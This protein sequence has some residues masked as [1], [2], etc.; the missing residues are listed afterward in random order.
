[1]HAREMSNVAP[2]VWISLNYDSNI[3]LMHACIGG[4]NSK[5]LTW[6]GCWV[7]GGL[8]WPQDKL[9]VWLPTKTFRFCIMDWVYILGGPVNCTHHKLIKLWVIYIYM[10]AKLPDIILLS[11]VLIII[12]L[13][14]ATHD[15]LPS[16]HE[17]WSNFHCMYT[18]YRALKNTWVPPLRV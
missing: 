11:V 2:R 12:I 18:C 7:M 17:A 9:Q 6:F 15:H 10:I 4:N 8:C 16:L 3:Q 13:I 14:I 5:F 1:M